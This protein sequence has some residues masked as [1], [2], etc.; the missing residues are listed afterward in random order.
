MRGAR[1]IQNAPRGLCSFGCD[2]AM[3]PA[4][5]CR[6]R[7]EG[8][9]TGWTW[10]RPH[11]RRGGAIPSSGLCAVPPNSRHLQPRPAARQW[12]ESGV[13]AGETARAAAAWKADTRQ[14]GPS[15]A[16]PRKHASVAALEEPTTAGVAPGPQHIFFPRDLALSAP[17]SP[18][19]C[20]PAA[21]LRRAPL[22]FRGRAQQLIRDARRHVIGS[23]PKPR[24]RVAQRL[25]RLLIVITCQGHGERTRRVADGHHVLPL[26]RHNHAARRRKCHATRR[27]ET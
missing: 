5:P 27:F 3:P 20:G 15:A 22:E 7:A 16:I 6:L 13:T 18:S 12:P 11:L 26:R 1:D 9:V 14:P 4:L 19:M 2:E 23:Q 24:H 10:H 21:D 17:R 8:R 25:R